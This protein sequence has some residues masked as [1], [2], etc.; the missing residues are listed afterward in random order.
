MSSDNHFAASKAKQSSSIPIVTHARETI[1]QS[2]SPVLARAA[3]GCGR[4]VRWEPVDEVRNVCVVGDASS[5]EVFVNDGA[6]VF[7]TRIYPATYGVSV[8]AAGA[9]VT[10]HALNI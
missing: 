7:S 6:L 5:A 10:Y 4:V 2:P 3:A 8:D 9:N 1:I